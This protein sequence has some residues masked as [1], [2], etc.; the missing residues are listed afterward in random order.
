MATWDAREWLADRMQVAREDLKVR[1]IDRY[2]E[3]ETQVRYEQDGQ[4]VAR[5]TVNGPLR[6]MLQ[7]EGEGRWEIKAQIGAGTGDVH[8]LELPE[9]DEII[10]E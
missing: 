3:T 7:K 2:G 8:R 6:E 9:T 10:Y 1:S 4:A 5:L